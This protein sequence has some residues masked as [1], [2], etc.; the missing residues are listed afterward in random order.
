MLFRLEDYCPGRYMHHDGGDENSYKRKYKIVNR[1]RQRDRKSKA[2]RF[3]TDG[4][5]L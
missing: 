5:L 3:R 1:F 2:E 4:G